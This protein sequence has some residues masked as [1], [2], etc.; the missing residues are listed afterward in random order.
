MQR[1][2]LGGERKE[3]GGDGN[4]KRCK[5]EGGEKSA[6]GAAKIGRVRAE[7]D[8]D[9][10]ASPDSN[11]AD[12]SDKLYHGW[13]GGKD[14]HDSG[15]RHAENGRPTKRRATQKAKKGRASGLKLTE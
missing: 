14:R 6:G 2:R 8:V 7:F 1:W 10:S 9:D 13:T 12:E 4:E 15:K 3:N 11:A 5:Y